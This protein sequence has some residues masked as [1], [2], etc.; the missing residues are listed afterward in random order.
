MGDLGPDL[1]SVYALLCTLILG[2]V[3]QRGVVVF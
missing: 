3:L 2:F 1:C